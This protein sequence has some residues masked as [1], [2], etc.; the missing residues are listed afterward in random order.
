MPLA[1]PADPLSMAGLPPAKTQTA[2]AVLD[3]VL[4]QGELRPT[5]ESLAASA[6]VSP[7]TVAHVLL[8]LR[9]GQLVST[10]PARL[11]LGFG[12]VLSVS[13]GEESC[14]AALVD[15]NGAL[16]YSCEEAPEPHQT[17][18]EPALLLARIKSIARRVVDAAG[19]NSNLLINSRLPLIGVAVAWPC[20][21]RGSKRPAGAILHPGW[22]THKP[23]R[24]PDA[25]AA[26]VGSPPGQTH[27]L[28][29]ANAHALAVAFDSAREQISSGIPAKAW[30]IG[31]VLRI[32]G[33]IGASAM[34]L[35]PSVSG[36]LPFVDSILLGGAR[37]LAGELGH[38]PIDA[39][40]V[41]E[42]N[43]RAKWI[44]G[45]APLSMEWRCNCGQ[46][47]HL[48]ALASGTAWARRMDESGITVP[49]LLQGMRRHQVSQTGAALSDLDDQRITYALEDLGRLIGRS[50]ASPILLLD[51]HSLTLTGSFAVKPVQDG[52]I[53]ERETWRHVFGDALELE[54]YD[55]QEAAFAGVRGA[56]LAVFRTTVYRR[57]KYW[58]KG[59]DA[60]L[61]RMAF[62]L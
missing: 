40:F 56:A 43:E 27:A 29:D 4:A 55:G 38:L 11:G 46:A 1:S 33:G 47:G 16:H 50:L 12:L 61:D 37:S 44:D 20:P 57:F 48:G 32:G 13:L 3:A 24:L 7:R 58:L 15:A 18:L 35:A 26:A 34:L 14:R 8:Q 19:K 5:H 2:E 41:K 28:N 17:K 60:E 36:R 52:V 30:Q 6:G 62:S 9:E 22:L 21:V 39:T 25:V 31:L 54:L 53:A 49:P 45:L 10:N 51:P 59:P 42:L 23:A